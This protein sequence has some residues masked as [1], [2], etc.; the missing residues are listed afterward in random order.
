M[1]ESSPPRQ[2]KGMTQIQC[3]N[4]PCSEYKIGA[5]AMRYDSTD[6]FDRNIPPYVSPS[7]NN[8]VPLGF[9]RQPYPAVQ[10]YPIAQHPTQDQG[11]DYGV[12]P[13]LP[14][15]NQST[16]L[17]Y[18]PQPLLRPEYPH[19]DWRIHGTIE[20]DPHART[21]ALSTG[22]TG[23]PIPSFPTRSNYNNPP[24]PSGFESVQRTTYVQDAE[25]T[26]PPLVQR[27]GRPLGEGRYLEHSSVIQAE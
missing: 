11:S 27:F 7:L 23:Q 22:A 2:S 20:R 9:A 5:I 15:G 6:N 10:A 25:G 26:G 16:W 19:G 1:D 3:L 4:S 14:Q 8:S 12:V 13:Y 24:L 18:V 17:R 21:T